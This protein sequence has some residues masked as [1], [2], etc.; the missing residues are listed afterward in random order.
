M[1]QSIVIELYLSAQTLRLWVRIQLNAW[2]SVG[3]DIVLM[4]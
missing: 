2:M 4:L 1:W 3:V